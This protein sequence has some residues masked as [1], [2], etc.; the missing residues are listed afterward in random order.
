MNASQIIA[1]LETTCPW[2]R[3]PHS[4]QSQDPD[5]RG[6]QGRLNYQPESL[7]NPVPGGLY[8]LRGPRRVGKSVE[9]KRAVLKLLQNGVAPRRLIYFPCDELAVADLGTLISTA[10]TIATGSES[11]PRYW[12]LDDITD[13]TG[14]W[15]T[16]L[17]SLQ[18]KEPEFRQDCIVLAGSSMR[19]ADDALTSLAGARG[20]A[21]EADRL[22][23][24][25]GFRDFCTATAG[26]R[27]LPAPSV[28]IRASDFRN[29]ACQSAI[30]ELVP[31]RQDLILAWENYL[32]IGGFPR[33]VVDFIVHSEVQQD[34]IHELFRAIGDRA[35][36]RSRDFGPA[37]IQMLLRLLALTLTRP[38]NR[39]TLSEGLSIASNTTQERIDDLVAALVC[40]PCYGQYETDRAGQAAWRG[41]HPKCYFTDPLFARLACLRDANRALCPELSALAEQ[42]FGLTLLRQREKEQPGSYS[43][44]DSVMYVRTASR[45]V[46]FT[47]PWMGDVAFVINYV[48][49]GWRQAART[50]RART[51]K[52]VMLTR[53]VLELGDDVWA[54][55][56]SMAAWLLDAPAVNG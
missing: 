2:W 31:W 5:F 17:R 8:F 7:P 47:A 23:L 14:K 3:N 41:A 43:R 46:D 10:R 26:A 54:V 50:L 24:P 28:Q 34:F 29:L 6:A 52:G 30:G 39:A 37:K 13:V 1:R 21:P 33:A 12:F 38:L 35:L 18:D 56:V 36:R 19:G 32:N 53:S 20:P 15:W 27:D 9:L 11:E 25:M 22:L 51:A 16:T 49:A 4:W 44:R 42:Q 55:P 48:D 40:W 45:E